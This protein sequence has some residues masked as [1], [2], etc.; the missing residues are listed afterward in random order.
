MT[1]STDNLKS[2]MFGCLYGHAVGDAIGAPYEFQNRDSYKYTSEMEYCKT[3]NLPAGSWTDDTSMM[4]CIA[5]SLVKNGDLDWKDVAGNFVNWYRKGM[6][7]KRLGVTKHIGLRCGRFLIGYMSVN[8]TCFD[9]G[10]GIRSALVTWIS[11][12]DHKLPLP[13]LPN[14]NRGA[15]T[16]GNGSIMRLSPIPIFFWRESATVILYKVALSSRITHS[17]A[18][19]LDGCMLM[20]AYLIRFI[21]ATDDTTPWSRKQTVM[22]PSTGLLGTSGTV[23]SLPLETDE[24]KEI[25]LQASYKTKDRSQI[26]TSGFV[27]HTLEAALWAL[28]RA[29]SFEEVCKSHKAPHNIVTD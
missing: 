7:R 5:A 3:F 11:K 20:A 29:N 13:A 24:I 16:S 12:M 2:R 25:H 8:G 17:S 10:N 4:L 18:L 19:S 21:R 14:E 23:M 27:V 22:H 1:T 15:N 6:S 9:I 26:K 28:W